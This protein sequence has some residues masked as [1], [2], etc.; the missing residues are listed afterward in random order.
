MKNLISSYRRYVAK[1]ALN[2]WIPPTIKGTM[3]AM[4]G[5]AAARQNEIQL[6]TRSYLDQLGAPVGLY[7]LYQAAG[8]EAN[9]AKAQYSGATLA[10]E[11]A[12]IANKWTGRGG[13]AVTLNTLVNTIV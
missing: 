2:P 1:L 12:G 8:A 7:W 5:N 10:N 13:N 6:R 11:L 3:A 9:K 4:Y